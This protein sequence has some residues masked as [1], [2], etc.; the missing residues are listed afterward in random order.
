MKASFLG[1]FGF[2]FF[3]FFYKWRNLVERWQWSNILNFGEARTGTKSNMASQDSIH[4]L[5]RNKDSLGIARFREHSAQAG[6]G[7]LL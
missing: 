2:F 3:F 4:L 1:F 7:L 6:L 5:V